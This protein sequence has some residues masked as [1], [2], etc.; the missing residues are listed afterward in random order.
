MTTTIDIETRSSSATTQGNFGAT[1]GSRVM[2]T[3]HVNRRVASPFLSGR[4]AALGVAGALLLGASAAQAG[5]GS[6]PRAVASAITSGSPDAIKSELERSEVLVCAAC[7]DYVLPLVD[8]PDASVR[9]V[10]GWWLARRAAGRQVFTNMLARLGQPDSTKARN[11]ADV[12]GAFRSP[13]AIPALGAALSNPVFTGEARAAMAKALGVIRRPAAAQPLQAVLGDADPMVRA[14]SLSALRNVEGFTDGTVAAPL[15][16]DADETVRVQAVFTVAELRT[17]S[18]VPALVQLLQSD[19]SA[20]VR[21]RAAWALGQM[22]ASG[23][24]AAPALTQASLS[25]P[26]P[27]VRSLA[28][29]A[30]ASLGK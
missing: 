8:S 17:T 14:A 16:A 2:T 27:F 19:P 29:A 10:A 28:H 20:N 21:K 7:V 25:D 13:Q 9:D 1:G 12:L 15:L 26:S 22:H 23:A 3:L 18:T 6:S 11:A 5:R 30:L 4:L 24:Q